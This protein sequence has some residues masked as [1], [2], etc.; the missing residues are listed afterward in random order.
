MDQLEQQAVTSALQIGDTV[1]FTR[2]FLQATAMVT[3]PEAPTSVGPFARGSVAAIA[4]ISPR[5]SLVLA[6]VTWADGTSSDVNVANL[7]RLRL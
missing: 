2:A 3:G 5:S 1:R 4:P 6:T 7:E